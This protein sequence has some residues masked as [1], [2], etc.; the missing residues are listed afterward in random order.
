MLPLLINLIIGWFGCGLV[1]RSCK[2]FTINC[3]III[4]M[5]GLSN[6]SSNWSRKEIIMKISGVFTS[7]DGIKNSNRICGYDINI[8][9]FPILLELRI[10]SRYLKVRRC[11][12]LR[13]I[14]RTFHLFL[15]DMYELL[16]GPREISFSHFK[17]PNQVAFAHLPNPNFVLEVSIW[18]LESTLCPDYWSLGVCDLCWDY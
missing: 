1:G 9:I 17:C 8:T 5:Q 16:D 11:W 10:D 13:W 4:I 3:S 15:V 14:P 12:D 2:G 7:F 6:E 18:C